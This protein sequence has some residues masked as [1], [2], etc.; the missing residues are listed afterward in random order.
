MKILVFAVIFLH[1][2]ASPIMVSAHAAVDTDRMYGKIKIKLFFIPVFVKS[3]DLNKIKSVIDD[4]NRES[5]QEKQS[6]PTQKGVKSYL[7]RAAKI[8]IARVRVRTVDIDGVFGSGDAAVTAVAVGSVG[9][10]YDGARAVAG[11]DG[12]CNIGAEYD[13]ERIYVDLYCIISFCLADTIYALTAGAL[14]GMRG[15]SVRSEVYG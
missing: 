4:D 10:A 15:K 6:K 5:G 1:I 13:Y 12:E 9:A 11:F 2:L 7:L 14:G 8:F 3:L